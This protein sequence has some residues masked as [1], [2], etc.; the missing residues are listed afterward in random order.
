MNGQPPPAENSPTKLP[1]Y[2]DLSGGFEESPA[3]KPG[4]REV[5]RASNDGPQYTRYIR[6]CMTGN[7]RMETGNSPVRELEVVHLAQR[8]E[9]QLCLRREG[10]HHSAPP[11]PFPIP[12]EDQDYRSRNQETTWYLRDYLDNPFGDSRDRAAKVES[13]LRNLGRRGDFGAIRLRPW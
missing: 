12:W 7:H 13:N 2:K 10:E 9:V 4:V 1:R 5:S 11:V 6:D 3:Y 8:G